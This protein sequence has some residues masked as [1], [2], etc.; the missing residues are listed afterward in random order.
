MAESFE[1]VTRE[2][3]LKGSPGSDT[4]S[5]QLVVGDVIEWQ[6]SLHTLLAASPA[7]L[8]LSYLAQQRRVQ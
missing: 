4:S 6:V 2:I 8:V 5:S 1:M 7:V 3:S